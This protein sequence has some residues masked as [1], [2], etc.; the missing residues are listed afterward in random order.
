[1]FSENTE[2]NKVR[3]IM[4]NDQPL[5][6]EESD[7]MLRV[8]KQFSKPENKTRLG[9][10]LS[11]AGPV[12][13]ERLPE[14]LEQLAGMG[15]VRIHRARPTLYWLPELE[16]Q[17]ASRF[18]EMLSE[19]PLT[20]KELERKL[21][22]VLAGWPPARRQELIERLLKERRIYKVSHLA[23][24]AKL[25]SVSQQLTPQDCVKVAL[26]LAIIKLKPKGITAEQVYAMAQE[27]SPGQTAPLQQLPVET[28]SLRP[29]HDQTEPAP[30]RPAGPAP[31]S[32]DLGQLI[33]DR[34]ILLKPGARNAAP[35]SLGEL[36][37][38]LAAEFADKAAFDRAV[39][40]LAASGRVAL[41]RHDFPSSLS[42]EDRDLDERGNYYISIA[43]RV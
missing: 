8:L 30:T 10:S 32:A 19:C 1:V 17:A 42:Q 40:Q 26:Q 12:Q 21:P 22:R 18:I 20:A 35:V 39:L 3:I 25:F 34:M 38:S 41:H 13:P 11:K 9:Q 31:D 27:L 36:R 7:F 4:P 37:R 28:E 43:L 15:Q 5:T 33:T 29:S 14:V 6:E 2:F 24:S 16:E 23:G